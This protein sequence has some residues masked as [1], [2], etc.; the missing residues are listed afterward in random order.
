M[1]KEG[2]THIV[3]IT[4]LSGAGKSTAQN[5]FEDRG[6]FTVD[7]LPPEFTVQLVEKLSQSS[8][9]IKQ[10]C[11]CVDIRQSSFLDSLPEALKAFKSRGRRV[12]VVFLEADD[13]VLIRR[14]SITRRIHP[15]SPKGS[16]V[17]GIK[18]ERKILAG[19]RKEA[20]IVLDTGEHTI[21][22]LR[23]KLNELFY[24]DDDDDAKRFSVNLVSF[25]FKDGVPAECDLVFDVRFLPNPYYVPNLKELS[26]LD[27]EV[28]EYVLSHDEAEE[29]IERT[30]G[31]LLFLLPLYK[32]AGKRYVTIGVG[33][34]GGMHRSVAIAHEI[35]A[36]LCV[37]YPGMKIHDRDR[38]K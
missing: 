13:E 15:M 3:F 12:D 2:Q 17:K 28:S 32:K 5:A 29:F 31:L 8:K 35:K 27:E 10:F 1:P 16:V 24:F 11:F 33:C 25:G 9:K 4:G 6:Y 7:N 36:R 26:G 22:S 21:Y 38:E 18:A 14:Y 30:A 20:N 37:K 34:T 23:E 19:I